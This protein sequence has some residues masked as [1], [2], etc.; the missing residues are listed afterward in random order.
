MLGHLFYRTSGLKALIYFLSILALCSM[1]FLV[2]QRPLPHGNFGYDFF[3]CLSLIII[4]SFAG[5]VILWDSVSNPILPRFKGSR[6]LGYVFFS[7]GTMWLSPLIGEI[8]H[9]PNNNSGV[10]LGGNGF[11]DA[12]FSMGFSV[13]VSSSVYCIINTI[14][15]KKLKTKTS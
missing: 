9:S 3:L 15:E 14:I 11:S 1:L 2:L 12:L 5:L 6:K 10:V 8:L 7:T 13:L 4:V